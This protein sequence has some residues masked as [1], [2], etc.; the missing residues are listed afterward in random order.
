[1]EKEPCELNASL[2]CLVDSSKTLEY[3][4]LQESLWSALDFFGIPY[5]KFD[6]ATNSPSPEILKKY[7]AI[8]IC[9]EHLGSSLSDYVIGAIVDAVKEGVGLVCFDG[10]LHKY[11]QPLKDSF[12][13]RTTEEPTHMPHLETSSVR[14]LNNRHFITSR[15][16][17]EF[18][19]FN[20]PVYVGNIVSIERPYSLLMIAANSSGCP[21]MFTE[22]LGKGR[23]VFSALSPKIWLKEYL[24]HGGGL[25][26]I[27]WRSIVWAARKPFAILA[28]PPFVTIR[29]DDCSGAGDFE[30]VRILNKHGFVPHVSLFIENIG[31]NGA[32]AIKSLYDKNAAEFSIHAFTW[33]K[34]A[35][36]KPRSPRDHS[37]GED[38]ADE[39]LTRF[40][41][42]FDELEARWGIKW[43]KVFTAH[44]GEVGK[45]VMPFLKKRGIKYMGIPYAFGAPYG[46]SPLGLKQRIVSNLR[47]FGGYGGVVDRY[48]EDPD[49]FIAAPSYSDI[50]PTILQTLIEKKVVTPE[51]Q[52]YDFLWETARE[53]VNVKLGA[54][55]AAF[56]IKFCLNMLSFAVLVT[57][58]QNISVLENEEWDTLLTY[59]DRFTSKYEK[60]FT[61]WEHIAKYAEN[62]R[63]VKLVSSTYDP[64]REEVT[65]LFEGESKMPLFLQVYTEQSGGIVKSY[66]EIPAFCGKMTLKFIPSTLLYKTV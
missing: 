18:I 27:F 14:I 48:P 60:I 40:F 10:D 51:G 2:I 24:G 22:T 49:L 21:V 50:P 38:F 12:G 17:F 20:K 54:W 34:Q 61:S 4:N 56:G 11:K 6:L 25:D 31:S 9:Q 45:R 53:K 62:H 39:E 59:V 7:G 15:R 65:C 26:D 37:E 55:Y 44:F 30:W 33:T 13:L 46:K 42:E 1:M 58:E 8:I 23:A 5:I 47:P 36:W 57:H 29:I 52:K 35:Y 64:E 32:K 3:E 41:K 63:N 28:L 19:R 66:K 43:S 16:I